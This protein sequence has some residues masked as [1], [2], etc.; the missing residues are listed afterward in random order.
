MSAP[1]SG[2]PADRFTPLRRLGGGGLGEVWSAM[3]EFGQVA[4]KTATSDRGRVALREEARLLSGLNHPG[5]VALQDCDQ[6][7]VWLAMDQVDGSPIHRWSRGRPLATVVEAVAQVAEVLAYL[8]AAGV[9][10]GDIK[11]SNVLIGDDGRPIVLDLGVAAMAGQNGQGQFYGTLGHAS[12]EQL[13]GERPQPATDVYALGAMAYQLVTGQAPFQSPDPAGLAWLPLKAL[14]EPPSS[15]RVR[16]PR[17]LDQLI[18]RML[19]RNPA[20]RPADAAVLATAL[21]ACL[22]GSP[23]Q[24]VIGMARV[25]DSLRRM[26]V[27]AADGGTVIG[28]VHGPKGSGRATLIREAMHAARREGLLAIAIDQVIGSN[29]R[30][31]WHALSEQAQGGS[32][33]VSMEAADPIAVPLAGQILADR[34]A[35]LVLIR[36][37]GPIG[38]LIALSARHLS[39]SRLTV[40]DV[41]SLLDMADEDRR[42]AEALHRRSGG[43]PGTIMADLRQV[44]V[45]ADLDPDER[46]LLQHIGSTPILV[47]DLAERMALSEHATLDLAEA[48]LDR[49][50]LSEALDGAALVRSPS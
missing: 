10:H 37:D 24:P 15:L 50:V 1:P 40:E 8:H 47:V 23:G 18:L 38:P 11:P 32:I 16:L 44:S 3:G 33:A 14:P 2:F 17:Q 27:E 28:V 42:A 12:P 6:D 30:E 46:A 21:R 9:V 4:V 49:G 20:S 35:A 41:G 22:S 7:G 26:V 36:A 29:P 45:P 34:G 31:R 25:R 39:P 48:L 19:A 13:R 5:L 43:L